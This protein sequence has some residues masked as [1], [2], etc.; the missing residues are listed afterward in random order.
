MLIPQVVLW[1][2]VNLVT[3]KDVASLNATSFD[4]NDEA[5]L[6]YLKCI[7]YII[8]ETLKILAEGHNFAVGAEQLSPPQ[9]LFIEILY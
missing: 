9:R 5:R 8:Q 4:L 1:H 7:P 3:T 6:M 2:L